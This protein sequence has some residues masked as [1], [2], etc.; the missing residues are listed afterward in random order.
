[1][2][3]LHLSQQNRAGLRSNDIKAFHYSRG[4]WLASPQPDCVERDQSCNRLKNWTEPQPY[5]GRLSMVVKMYGGE[6]EAS[7]LLRYYQWTFSMY[8]KL[9]KTNYVSQA[10]NAYSIV[11]L[12]AGLYIS[13]HPT[14]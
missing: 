8:I 14:M 1:M 4:A 5:Y 6:A 12:G 2:H 10:Q 13:C 11:D 3:C 9:E 7:A